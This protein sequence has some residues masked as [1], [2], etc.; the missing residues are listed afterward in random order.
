MSDEEIIER[1]AREMC[2][3]RGIDPD[4]M[5]P[6]TGYENAPTI[7]SWH[8]EAE[9]AQRALVAHRVLSPTPSPHMGDE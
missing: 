6:A 5:R 8:I 4:R 7:P 1:L 2:I 3:A 9:W